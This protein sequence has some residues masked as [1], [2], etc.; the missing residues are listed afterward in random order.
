MN[1]VTD[2]K[3][4]RVLW[5]LCVCTVLREEF[6]LVRVVWCLPRET[7]DVLS[8]EVSMSSWKQLGVTWDGGRCP[9]PG[10]GVWNE[11]VIRSFPNHSVT[12]SPNIYSLMTNFQLQSTTLAVLELYTHSRHILLKPSTC[13]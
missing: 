5:H 13:K 1:S 2:N 11:K 3:L 12:L 4:Q 6:C 7:V 8:L 10:Q 9:C